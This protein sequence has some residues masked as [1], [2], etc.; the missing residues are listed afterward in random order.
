[1][2]SAQQHRKEIPQEYWNP[3][4][5]SVRNPRSSSEEEEEIEIPKSRNSSKTLRT[6][7][8]VRRRRRLIVKNPIPNCRRFYR[9]VKTQNVL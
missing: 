9:S 1:L 4:R 3:H 2:E 6:W 5:S 8:A 7:A